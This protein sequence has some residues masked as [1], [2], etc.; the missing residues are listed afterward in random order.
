MLASLGYTVVA[1]SGKAAASAW[2]RG[3]GAAEVMDRQEL[4]GPGKPLERQRWAAAVDCV[5]GATLAG[6]LRAVRYGGAVAASGVTGGAALETTVMPFILR[7]VSLLGID[8]VEVPRPERQAL[9][10]R[11][12]GELRP[13]DLAGLVADE[14]D[15]ASVPSAIARTLAGQVRGR[16]LVAPAG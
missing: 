14:I 10:A 13:P 2:L 7:S 8:S 9:W 15:L 16:T 6:I 5:G 12:A 1:S 11:I 3:L 4:A